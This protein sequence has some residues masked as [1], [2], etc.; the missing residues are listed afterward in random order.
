M[1]RTRHPRRNAVVVAVAATAIATAWVGWDYR[2]R[3]VIVLGPMVQQVTTDGF[4]LFGQVHPDRAV[5]VTLRGRD[6]ENPSGPVDGPGLSSGWVSA[7]GG[8]RFI[9]TF[10]G[11]EPG[12]TYEYEIRCGGQPLARH[13]VRTAP[14]G[15]RALR[16]VA[17][18]DSGTGGWSQYRLARVMEQYRPDFLLH[19][20]D[21][22]YPR[23]R[24]EGFPNK[25]FRPYGRML[26]EIP[27]YACLGNHEYKL[28]GVDPVAEA[29]VFPPNG[30]A[31]QP[32]ERN[33]WFDYADARFVAIDSNN[34]EWFFRDVAA[35]WLDEVLRAAGDRWKIVFFHE[36]VYT[37]GRYPPAVKLLRT[38]VPVMERHGVELVLC[39]HNHMFER[40]HPIRDGRIAEPGEGTVY[41]TT[42]AG[43]A[44]LAEVRLPMPDTIAVWNDR[45]HS[46]TLADLAPDIIVLR[47]IGESGLLIDEYHVRRWASDRGEK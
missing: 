27:M 2:R 37:Q 26:A 38:I 35:P 46:F 15:P 8:G 19:T 9:A 21:L 12:R 4:A 36:P 22:I 16:F 29:F 13:A 17:F 45:Q 43:G 11:M 7:Q 18:G 23:G 14:P 10:A 6:P 33:Y 44:N 39:G 3:P 47:Q 41:V 24:I 31:G 20:G 28:K 5:E 34:D 1:I 42:G 30:P 32:P 25:F 40:T